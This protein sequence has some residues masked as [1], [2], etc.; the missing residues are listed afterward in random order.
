MM[1]AEKGHV[2]CISVLLANG[3]D[4]NFATLK[5]MGSTCYAINSLA[6]ID[7]FFIAIQSTETRL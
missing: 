6:L 1:A 2:E 4:V 7:D 5:V 3:V